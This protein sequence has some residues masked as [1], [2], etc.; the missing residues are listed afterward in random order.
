MLGTSR[1]AVRAYIWI[2]WCVPAPRLF[3]I[4]GQAGRVPAQMLRLLQ[5]N[6]FERRNVIELFKPPE[7]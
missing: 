1:N 6:C 2:A 3:E 4:Q 7:K 5:L